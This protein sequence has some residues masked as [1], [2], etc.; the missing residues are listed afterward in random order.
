MNLISGANY[1]RLSGC[2]KQVQ[3]AFDHLE[4]Y[5]IQSAYY[6]EEAIWQYF[7]QNNDIPTFKDDV[8]IDIL[9]AAMD[10]MD[11]SGYLPC[12]I[13]KTSWW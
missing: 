3:K 2:P 10:V 11:N 1:L 9:Q 8:D 5:N 4:K 6:N 7:D 12:W 13:E